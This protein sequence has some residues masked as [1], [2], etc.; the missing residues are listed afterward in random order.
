[1]TL[2]KRDH[3]V[4]PGQVKTFNTFTL[5]QDNAPFLVAATPRQDNILSSIAIPKAN[6]R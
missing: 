5:P 4:A 2:Y 1:V 6:L 3:G